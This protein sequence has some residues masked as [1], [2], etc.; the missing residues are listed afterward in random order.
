VGD[1]PV[2]VIDISGM[3]NYAKQARGPILSATDRYL[4]VCLA[5]AVR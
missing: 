3:A 2:V 1:E 4:G 5:S